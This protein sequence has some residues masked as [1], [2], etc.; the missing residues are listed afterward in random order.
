MAKTLLSDILNAVGVKGD[1]AEALA[2][3]LTSISLASLASGL[4]CSHVIK[5]AGKF[6]TVGGAA[7]E[8]QTLSGVVAGDV[9][10]VSL[11]TAGSTPRTILSAIPA[12]NKISYVFSGDPAAD[13][14]VSYM[15]LRA[16][17]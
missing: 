11:Q 5:Y 12:T 8:D 16:A 9:V 4:A 17:S 1:V 15:V 10:L 7:A 2:T 14:V 6:T 13:H 3:R